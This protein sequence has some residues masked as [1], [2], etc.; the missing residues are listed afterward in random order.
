MLKHIAL[1]AILASSL[2]VYG[3]TVPQRMPPGG[4]GNRGAP[5]QPSRS[6]RSAPM[7]LEFGVLRG[8][9]SAGFKDPF[10]SKCKVHAAVYLLRKWGDL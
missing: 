2:A 5:A 1:T 6:Y 8:C 9:R 7:N 10:R 3:W 4:N